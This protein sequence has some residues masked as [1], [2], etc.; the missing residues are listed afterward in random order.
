MLTAGECLK[1]TQSGRSLPTPTISY[2]VN[3]NQ[4]TVERSQDLVDGP[5]M[6]TIAIDPQ[7]PIDAN[8]LLR[9][10]WAQM[11][12]RFGRLEWQFTP[13]RFGSSQ[14]I[15]FGW[16]TLGDVSPNGVE[17]SI[18]YQRRGVPNSISFTPRGAIYERYPN[19]DDD[20]RAAVSDA[21]ATYLSPP[22][23]KAATQVCSWTGIP[24]NL[25]VTD[26]W[27]IAPLSNGSTEIGITVRAFD[28]IDRDYEFQVRLSPLLDLLSVLTNCVFEQAKNDL[29][30]NACELPP[31]LYLEDT[32]WLDGAPIVDGRLRLE[33][34]HIEFGN[35]IV[36][37]AIDNDHRLLRSA[38]LFNEGL[39]LLRTSSK[40]DLAT[41][42]LISALEAISI[43][44]DT[45]TCPSCGQTIYTIS[46]RVADLGTRHLGPG[47]A[48]IFEDHYGRRSQ[49]LHAG[50]LY[51]TQPMMNQ[52]IPQLDPSAPEGCAMPRSMAWPHNLMEFTSFIIRQEIR[53]Y[54]A[55]PP[56]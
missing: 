43:Q 25:Y 42:L 5:T 34:I 40:G 35:K 38:R 23:V 47:S 1:S 56:I 55:C 45:S 19:L 41:V 6:V 7:S 33:E 49:Y 9:A 10:V 37:S 48:W 30:A 15:R 14:L 24:L 17:I 29:E 2:D 3:P 27:K 54:M 26:R 13:R 16:A 18:Q 8:L 53:D 51:A 11:R 28:D 22:D 39:S 32:E 44:E 12:A 31:D 21:S 20:L 4:I 46:K 36:T 52:V 50:K